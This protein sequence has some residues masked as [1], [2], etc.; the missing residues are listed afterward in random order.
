MHK[1]H[2]CLLSLF[3]TEYM[4][5][6]NTNQMKNKWIKSTLCSKL[7]TTYCEW[8]NLSKRTQN[9]LTH[10]GYIHAMLLRCFNGQKK[11]SGKV[12]VWWKW[13]K[14]LISCWFFFLLSFLLEQNSWKFFFFNEVPLCCCH[15][16]MTMAEKKSRT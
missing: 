12:Y 1:R 11:I 4:Y 3:E 6:R 16:V 8:E 13:T 10:T 9:G 14:Q 7:K 2:D 5:I 15:N